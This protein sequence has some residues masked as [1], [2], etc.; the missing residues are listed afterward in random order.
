MS[1]LQVAINAILNNMDYLSSGGFNALGF[2]VLDALAL[3]SNETLVAHEA[4]T[5][6]PNAAIIQSAPSILE[7]VALRALLARQEIQLSTA[8]H[9]TV[10]TP[11]PEVRLAV[12]AGA[13]LIS[14]A[15]W[16][17]LAAGVL[18]SQVEPTITRCASELVVGHTVRNFTMVIFFAEGLRALLTPM[19]GFELTA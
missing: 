17:D 3:L 18:G 14:N 12:C 11:Q 1:I 5:I 7:L 15:T 19:I 2:V 10:A 6:V 16:L 8:F 9:D 4:A 13:P